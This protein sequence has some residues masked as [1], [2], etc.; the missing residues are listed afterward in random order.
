[1]LDH[2]ASE[3]VLPPAFAVVNPNRLDENGEYGYIA[4][5]G[6]T[7][8]F[9]V[10]VNRALREAGWYAARPEPNLLDFLDLVALGTVCDVVKLVG[11]NRAFVAQGL[12]IMNQRRNAGIVALAD[13]CNYKKPFD[14]Y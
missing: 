3:P 8:L 13:I 7:Y 6:V 1:V 4:A 14:A 12:K 11:L 10:A 5:V 2:H 9:V